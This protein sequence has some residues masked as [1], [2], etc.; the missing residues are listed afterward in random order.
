MSRVCSAALILICLILSIVSYLSADIETTSGSR[1][2]QETDPILIQGDADLLAKKALYGWE[3]DG[4]EEDPVV[5]EDL[6]VVSAGGRYC[7][8]LIDLDRHFVVRNCTLEGAT[9]MPEHGVSLELRNCTNG[10]IFS[11]RITGSIVGISATDC[12]GIRVTENWVYDNMLDGIR[13]QDSVDCR[14]DNNSIW[15]HLDGTGVAALGSFGVRIEDNEVRMTFYGIVGEDCPRSG[16]TGNR[17]DGTDMEIGLWLQSSSN[18]SIHSN[19]IYG[20][21]TC[22]KLI[23]MADCELSGNYIHEGG[24]PMHIM[25]TPRGSIH[26]NLLYLNSGPLQ[27]DYSSSS[28]ECMGL[29]IWNNTFSRNNGADLI[30]NKDNSQA[31]DPGSTVKFFDPVENRGNHWT[32]LTS[33]DGDGD[34]IVDRE[35][36]LLGD[37]N[38]DPYPLVSSP[39]QLAPPPTRL[40]AEVRAEDI[41]VTWNTRNARFDLDTEGFRVYRTEH[42]ESGDLLSV[43]TTTTAYFVDQIVTPG[44]SYS[45]SVLTMTEAGKGTLS[46]EVTVTFDNTAP[47]VRLVSPRN[48]QAFNSPTIKVQWDATEEE[49]EIVRTEIELDDDSTFDPGNQTSYDLD[50][51]V[52]GDHRVR[53][54][55]WNSIGLSSSTDTIA[56]I[57]DPDQPHL[58]LPDPELAY[59]NQGRFVLYWSMSDDIT[60]IESVMVR[61]NGGP[62][63]NISKSEQQY[64]FLLGMEGLNIL[65]VMVTDKAGNLATAT[66]EV[67]LDRHAPLISILGPLDGQFLNTTS[68]TVEIDVSDEGSGVSKTEVRLDSS[69]ALEPEG[70]GKVTFNSVPDGRHQISVHVSDKAGNVRVE[71]IDIVVDTA[72]PYVVQYM[73]RGD[74]VPIDESIWITLSESLATVRLVVDGVEG[75]IE[76]SGPQLS[77]KPHSDLE[78]ATVYSVTLEGADHAGNRVREHSWNFTTTDVGFVI[79]TVFGPGGAPIANQ[80]VNME[81]L[82]TIRTDS[83]GRF[84]ISYSMGAYELNITKPGFVVFNT[85]FRIEPGEVTDL[86]NI[87]LT[88]EKHDDGSDNRLLLNVVISIMVALLL[89]FLIIFYFY[90]RYQDQHTISED[91]REQ[92]LQILRHFD[93]SMKIDQVDA[94][95]TLGVDRDANKKQIRKAYRK[96]AAKY[97]P[98]RAMHNEDYDVD[99]SHQRMGEINAAK[100]I[101][102][103]DQKR[104]LQDRILRITGR[105]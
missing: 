32:D 9:N 30:F 87:R 91:D 41:R 28:L 98:D 14:V 103:D 4:S 20:A 97:H 60:E 63:S 88:E 86:G 46:E 2:R 40:N 1:T 27:L 44:H 45:Y 50:V 49:T 53:V 102:L 57:Y 54:K 92:M 58:S 77:F 89:V 23:Q 72:S 52:P 56:F 39:V 65:D 29:R 78:Y 95:E 42:T 94:Y 75:E 47:F 11:N 67:V 48:Y 76:V 81:G 100:T 7:L 66:K 55:V 51:F 96:L 15:R 99:D 31:S 12:C 84:N 8:K 17:V 24:V 5:I 10:T 16:I 36:Q 13:V 64:D 3:G 33:P 68:I 35:Y 43:V 38:T 71:R 82:V 69:S 62:W 59:T 105:Y 73:P 37:L 61:Q 26:D 83:N 19:E 79:G 80:V 70:S 74:Q 101:L 25:F 34:G 90:R 93:V 85:S 21:N 6:N 104:D 22:M 18:S